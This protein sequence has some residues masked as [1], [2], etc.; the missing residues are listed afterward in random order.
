MFVNIH[1][2]IFLILITLLTKA[3]LFVNNKVLQKGVKNEHLQNPTNMSGKYV[4]SMHI[5]WCAN[6]RALLLDFY[7]TENTSGVKYL[8]PNL[9]KYLNT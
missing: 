8:K 6:N 5:F 7:F 4:I 3:P 9:N 2:L 1:F